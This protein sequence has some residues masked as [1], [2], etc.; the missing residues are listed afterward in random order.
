[1]PLAPIV[2]RIPFIFALAL[3]LLT[4]CPDD[5]PSTADG[6]QGTSTGDGGTTDA[7]PPP[8]MAEDS[9]SSGNGG[10]DGDGTTS[11]SSDG[12]T[13]I[14]SSGSEGSDGTTTGD[15][16]TL[17]ETAC[18]NFAECKSLPFE[19]CVLECDEYFGDISGFKVCEQAAMDLYTCFGQA[20]CDQIYEGCEEEI[21]AEFLAC[22]KGLGCSQFVSGALDGSS[23]SV[24][25]TCGDGL[26][27]VFECE[28]GTC[29]CLETGVETGSCRQGD[30][31]IDLA[32]GPALDAALLECCGWDP[33][34]PPGEK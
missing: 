9:G 32:E 31:C 34:V 2:P 24:E 6:G 28:A 25:Q 27:R 7:T 4:G 17:C 1:M 8:G 30:V 14:G 19:D 10:G 26:D 22:E 16:G 12:D 23:C 20:E 15:A 11:D 18:A 3:P 13:T 21:E 33:P 29:T 5:T